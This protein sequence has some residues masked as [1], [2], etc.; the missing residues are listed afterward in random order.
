LLNSIS[1]NHFSKFSNNELLSNENLFTINNNKVYLNN[2]RNDG[3]IQEISSK[4]KD[5]LNDHRNN[6]K[7]NFNKNN[8][9]QNFMFNSNILLEE[10]LNNRFDFQ[11]E[12]EGELENIK[13]K[14]RNNIALKYEQMLLTSIKRNNNLND[15]YSDQ[16]LNNLNYNEYLNKNNLIDYLFGKNAF[17]ES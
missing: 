13:S 1:N 4:K 14:E 3:Y 6:I 17:E 2:F 7:N 10:N 9:Q 8:K 11:E 15:F 12:N 16:N 5:F